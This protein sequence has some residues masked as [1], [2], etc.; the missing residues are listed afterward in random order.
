MSADGR[1]L[2]RTPG[3]VHA[4]DRPADSEPRVFPDRRRFLFLTGTTA[5]GL[6]VAGGAGATGVLLWPVVSY[7]APRRYAIGRPETLPADR[8]AFLPERRI[9]VLNTAEGVAA[10]SAV[11]T[12]LGCTVR[13][14]EG[15][16]YSCP[17]HGS[18]FDREGRVLDG[19]APKP[20]AWYRVGLSRR[21]ELVVDE[22]QVVDPT[23][24]FKA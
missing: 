9:Y 18:R 22:R 2:G 13:H 21:G 24:R 19:P 6:G 11:C 15:E 20:L 3:E 23:H 4:A 14:V 17:C 8:P 5:V 16:G 1:P 12:H 7:E 10:V